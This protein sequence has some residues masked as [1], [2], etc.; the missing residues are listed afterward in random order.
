MPTPPATEPAI[1]E[2]EPDAR[3]AG[4]RSGVGHPAALDRPAPPAAGWSGMVLVLGWNLWVGR[5]R[6][7]EVVAHVRARAA[8]WSADREPPLVILL[9]E[10]FRNGPA[11]PP[12]GGAFAASDFSRRAFPEHDIVAAAREL[13]MSLRYVPSM[14]NGGHRS[15]RGN[16]ILSTLPLGPARAWELPL[17]LQRRV[18]LAAT[19]HLPDGRALRVCSAHLDPRGGSARDVFGLAGRARQART[20]LDGLGRSEGDAGAAGPTVLGADLNLAR[21]TREAAYRIL[22]EAGFRHGVPERPPAW[23]HTYHRVPRLLLDWIL[24]RDPAG[25]VARLDVIRLDEDPADRGPYVFGSDHHPLLAAV[26]FAPARE[27]AP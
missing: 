3:L 2:L 20:L 10:A 13:G 12:T 26:R 19:A 5:G 15:D 16:A 1:A 14:R 27:R 6:L 22:S 21:G 7:A 17:V 4:W 11:V 24:V 8:A 25:A 23:P 18:A 9:Q